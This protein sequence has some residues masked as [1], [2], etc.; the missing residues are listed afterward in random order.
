MNA[1]MC[2][3]AQPN[4][5]IG[6]GRKATLSY[7]LSGSRASAMRPSCNECLHNLKKQVAGRD[8]IIIK[9]I[10]RTEK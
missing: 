3:V 4:H 7:R 5:A 1:I 6:C 10:E 9:Q 2:R 8:K